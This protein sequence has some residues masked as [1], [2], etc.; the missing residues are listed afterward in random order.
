MRWP[1]CSRANIVHPERL[2]RIVAIWQQL[3]IA[4]CEQHVDFLLDGLQLRPSRRKKGGGPLIVEINHLRY[5]GAVRCVAA[6]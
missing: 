1:E 2:L 3:I 6:N 5:V 4:A